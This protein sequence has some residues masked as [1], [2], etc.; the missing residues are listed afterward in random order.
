MKTVAVIGMGT[1]GAPMASNLLKAGYDVVV[2]NRTRER[3]LPLEKQG[4]TRARTPAEAA[5]GASVVLLCVSDT[6]DVEHLLLGKNGVDDGIEDGGLIIDCSTISPSATRDF[7]RHFAAR[8]VG[9]VDAP[10]SGGSEGAIHGTLAVMCGAQDAHF[11]R[12]RPVLEA[13][14]GSITLV[15]PPGAGQVAKA[16]N[17][18]VISGTYQ[19]VAEGIVLA[20]KA[21]VDPESVIEA[22][23]GGAAGSWVLEN[24]AGNMIRD[25][26]P[27]GF[28]VRLHR[29][30]LGIA[31]ETAR[32]G[33]AVL[34][35]AAYVA[36]SEDGLIADGHG[37]EDMS[38]IARAVR[39]G[40]GVPDG[41]LD[42]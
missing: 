32:D 35:I 40:S 23:A 41:P 12:A 36:T 34:P 37:D 10:V 15:G 4:A 31:L 9:F 2:H 29:K 25:S 8:D 11:E 16:V 28:R 38:A 24:R 39:R 6:P 5:R 22:I 7:A 21:G 20:H 13:I 17:Q 42:A 19:A 30:D 18:V 33:G 26:Y 3:E 1:M 14:G 27:L